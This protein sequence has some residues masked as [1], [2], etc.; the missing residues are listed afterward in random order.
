M[1][2]IRKVIFYFHSNLITEK[3]ST[4]EECLKCLLNKQ[5]ILR[6]LSHIRLQFFSARDVS[7]LYSVWATLLLL[8]GNCFE[9]NK[10]Q[11]F[12]QVLQNT[13]CLCSIR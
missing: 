1:L 6:S 11:K 5:A 10:E 4:P 2:L 13:P 7:I 12:F 3:H 8:C 9:Q